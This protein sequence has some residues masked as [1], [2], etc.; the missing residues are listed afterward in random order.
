MLN[1]SLN[2]IDPTAPSTTAAP[3]K[4]RWQHFGTTFKYEVVAS[5]REFL[6]MDALARLHTPS[7][8]ETPGRSIQLEEL[9][10]PV[11]PLPANQPVA[12]QARAISQPPR[13]EPQHH[14][15]PQQQP[16]PRTDSSRAA[17]SQQQQRQSSQQQ[18]QQ[19]APA[20]QPPASSQQQP[21]VPA[22]TPAPQPAAAP[23]VTLAEIE[24]LVERRVAAAVAAERDARER[25]VR[26]SREDGERRLKDAQ[27]DFDAQLR[28]E[29]DAR[30]RMQEE[31]KKE[32]SE[33]RSSAASHVAVER[34]LADVQAT[35]AASSSA[36]ADSR[37]QQ[38][39]ADATA[40]LRQ[41]AQDSDREL[42]ALRDEVAAI[43]SAT[44]QHEDA[45]HQMRGQLVGAEHRYET[46]VKEFR[47]IRDSSIAATAVTGTQLPEVLD[48]ARELAGRVKV[49][50]VAIDRLYNGATQDLTSHGRRMDAIERSLEDVRGQ[51]MDIVR[52]GAASPNG[53]PYVTAHEAE[54]IASNAANT[55]A[56]RVHDAAVIRI[57]RCEQQQQRQA[58]SSSDANG[59]QQRIDAL[60]RDVRSCQ[61]KVDQEKLDR[62]RALSDVVTRVASIPPP[63]PTTNVSSTSGAEFELL[64]RSV[65]KNASD[66]K[67]LRQRVQK[68]EL[69]FASV[70][71]LLENEPKREEQIHALDIRVD[72]LSQQ[73]QTAQQTLKRTQSSLQ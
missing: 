49:V 42:R 3:T 65:N 12:G 68:L 20:E 35:V 39:C 11:V 46:L 63:A 33:V 18:Q 2:L 13:D 59:V 23:A 71:S 29:R 19:P 16:V 30:A 60:D 56:A 44:Q 14:H 32:V 21:P 26:E 61:Q 34:A 48:A 73:M 22:P 6:L 51:A 5:Y 24:L 55:A 70:E 67:E 50:E 57:E 43:A 41:H 40:D 72:A 47:E 37:L 15:Q 4:L 17:P 66:A 7:S 52:R 69:S 1:H 45:Q 8:Q 27:A 64:Q 58:P 36:G 62:E 38:V 9:G 53:S 31:F 54:A 10:V 28:H 25:A